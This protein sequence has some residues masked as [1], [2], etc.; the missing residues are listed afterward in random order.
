M[1]SEKR[2]RFEGSAGLI[3]FAC[4]NLKVP[5]AWQ[6][7]GYLSQRRTSPLEGIFPVALTAPSI[8]TAGVEKMPC[9]AISARSADVLNLGGYSSFGNCLF[10]DP[11]P[12]R[13]ISCNLVP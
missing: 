5:P 7:A 9:L 8:T 12:F 6:Q 2:I 13:D 4:L 1:F 3:I 10:H 11:S